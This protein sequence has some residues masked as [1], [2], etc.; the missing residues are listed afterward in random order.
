[1]VATKPDLLDRSILIELQ[2]ISYNERK[3][4]KEL[5]LSFKWDKP[6]ILGAIFSILSKALEIKK[7]LNLQLLPRMADFAYYGYAVAEVLGYGGGRF[8]QAYRGNIKTQNYQVIEGNPVA[9]AMVEFMKDK[10][11]WTGTASELLGHLTKT[12]EGSKFNIKDRSWPKTPNGLSRR[13]NIL[14]TN[15]FETGIE[16]A[17]TRESGKRL[18]ILKKIHPKGE[19][20]TVITDHTVTIAQE[21]QLQHDDTMTID[22]DNDDKIPTFRVKR[23]KNTIEGFTEENIK[24]IEEE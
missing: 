2:R 1:V 13:L 7:T 14:K 11:K 10:E 20:N 23:Q 4:D 9:V 17:F 3:Q 12:A 6:Y 19:K 16:C 5:Q 24:I 21:Q 22:D 8:L 15:F 18:I